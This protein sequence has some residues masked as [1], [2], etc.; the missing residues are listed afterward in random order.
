MSIVIETTN[1]H[2][3]K[4]SGAGN[5]FYVLDNDKLGLNIKKCRSVTK[6][7]CE[8]SGEDFSPEG[9]MYINRNERLDF[10]VW[11]Y[12][13][14]GSTGMMCGNGGRCAVRF[15]REKGYTDKDNYIRFLM[16]NEEY[17]AKIIDGT[18]AIYLPEPK[19]LT[20]MSVDLTSEHGEMFLP[21]TFVK[22][23][24]EHFC[25]DI[26]D[27][28]NLEHTPIKMFPLV[29]I[30]RR[31]RYHDDFAPRGT[32]FNLYKIENKHKIILR[33]YERGVEAETG[34]CG[35]GAIAAAYCA[36]AKGCEFPVEVVP[37]SGIPIWVSGMPEEKL[38]ELKGHA[39]FI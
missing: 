35:T 4:M 11:F 10:E 6:H 29:L 20:K 26:T 19:K 24:T 7:L 34:A 28:P 15:A 12:N 18:V 5:L 9:V 22:N 27:V 30:G 33:T 2:V 36:V 37:S 39:E 25:S 31:V 3:F 13:P 16:A 38:T 17:M 14:D 21:G 32:N 23:G 8:T 1:E